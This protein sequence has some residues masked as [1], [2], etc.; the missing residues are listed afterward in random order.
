GFGPSGPQKS[1]GIVPAVRVS[2]EILKLR[3]GPILDHL[4]CY[5][6]NGKNS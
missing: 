2:G 6:E 3:S 1:P 5:G 4:N